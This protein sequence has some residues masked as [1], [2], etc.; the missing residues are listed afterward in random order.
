MHA[1]A[2]I[3]YGGRWCVQIGA[4]NSPEQAAS[5]K[6]ELQRRYRNATVLQFTGSTGE[7]V[8]VRVKD[9]EKERA[10]AVLRETATPE[11]AAFLVRLD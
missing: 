3:D 9:D 4:F 6:R 7:W 8:R 2:P 11:G 1:P 10:E 5:F